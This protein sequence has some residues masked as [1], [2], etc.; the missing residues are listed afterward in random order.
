[1]NTIVGFRTGV[2]GASF[3]AGALPQ[4]NENRSSMNGNATNGIFCSH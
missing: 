2:A 4:P 3:G 1:M